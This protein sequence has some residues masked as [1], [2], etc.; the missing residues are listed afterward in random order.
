MPRLTYILLALSLCLHPILASPPPSATLIKR[1]G[2]A[3]KFTKKI[4]DT[5]K[6]AGEIGQDLGDAVVDVLQHAASAL[7]PTVENIGEAFSPLVEAIGTIFQPV[8]CGA[9]SKFITPGYDQAASVFQLLN[10]GREPAVTTMEENFFLYALFGDLVYDDIKVYYGAS[11]V[12]GWDPETTGVT[13]G[14]NV[15]FRAGK[16]SNP[17]KFD[18]NV[19]ELA[20]ELAHCKQYRNHGWSIAAFGERYLYQWCAA[21]FSYRGNSFEQEA[22]QVSEEVM[23]RL[24]GETGKK[25]FDL[26]QR[27]D[28]V[29]GLGFPT[30]GPPVAVAGAVGKMWEMK[31]QLGYVMLNERGCFKVLTA[32]E[33]EARKWATCKRVNC[34][35]LRV[36]P[37]PICSPSI[38]E[39]NEE[40]DRKKGIWTRVLKGAYGFLCVS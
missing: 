1:G 22:Y 32:E 21:G 5:V 38:R 3:K 6:Q 19:R 30:A 15:Y 31:F 4:T 40:C 36:A 27:R 12:P 17:D 10:V 13:M 7:E 33:D 39:R 29:A 26:W 8:V 34:L 24:L 20:H 9:V 23:P 14:R 11:F 18:G 2:W 16:D 28:E 25:Y 37:G 35:E